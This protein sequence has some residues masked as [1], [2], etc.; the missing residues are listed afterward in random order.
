M[1]KLIVRMLR[2]LKNTSGQFISIVLILA[3]GSMLFAG[4]FGAQTAMTR[5]VDYYYDRQNLADVWLY[6]KG[7]SQD[8][9]DTLAL[10][11]KVHSAEGRYAYL[12]KLKM[13]TIDSELMIHSITTINSSLLS[14]GVLPTQTD[15]IMVDN[16]YARANKLKLKDKLPISTDSGI[17]TVTIT[18]F[19]YNPEAVV[20]QKDAS[21]SSVSHSEFG[22]AYATNN[23]L[24]GLNRTTTVYVN[25]LNEMDQKLDD[26]QHGLDDAAKQ[27]ADAQ[28]QYSQS[29]SNAQ[30]EL[31]RAQNQLN[32]AKK[33]LEDGRAT[34]D[35]QR[36]NAT[37]QFNK[38][39][40]QLD[41]ASVQLAQ[42]KQQAQIDLTNGQK[43][44]DETKKQMDNGQSEL[45]KQRQEAQAQFTKLQAPL[46]DAKLQLDQKEE[47]LNTSFSEYQAIRSQL[48]P[49]QQEAQDTD[50]TARNDLLAK[51]KEALAVQQ[52]QLK[53]KQEQVQ[54]QLTQKE[55]QL[56]RAK[57]NYENGL[58]EFS[59]RKVSMETQLSSAQAE[60]D[61]KQ[62]QLNEQWKKGQ[63]TLADK[64]AQLANAQK[65][66]DEGLQQYVAKKTDGGAQ[67]SK[68]E[69]E[70]SDKRLT[71]EEKRGDFVDEKADAQAQL[72]TAVKN[73]QE[74][75]VRTNN[76]AAIMKLVKANDSYVTAFERKDQISY[77]TV[78]QSLDPLRS[79]SLIFPL[80]F[81][82]V[83]AVIAFISI[84]KMVETQRTQ[85]AVMQAIGISRNKIRTSFLIY[86]FLAAVLG[87]I[88]FAL[89]GNLLIP[90]YL[91]QVFTTRL[92]MPDLVVSI[93]PIYI[94]LP[95][96]FAF[97]STGAAALLALQKTLREDPAHGMRP[98]PPKT[99]KETL[100]E[101]SSW[102]WNRLASS[103]RLVCRN[104]LRNKG[105][106][107]LSSVGVIASVTLLVTGFS[108]KNS[109]TDV[110]HSVV[111]GAGYDIAIN[112]NETVAD[113]TALSFPY[114]AS[115]VELTSVKKAVV[116]LGEGVTLKAQIV[117]SGSSLIHLVDP[118]GNTIPIS[119][120]SFIIPQ[121]IAQDYA[122]NV[123]DSMNVEINNT[124]YH[125]KITA[126]SEQ[127]LAK[128]L[129][130]SQDLA[131]NAGIEIDQKM[132]LVKL[133]NPDNT[134]HLA[135]QLKLDKTVSDVT[136]RQDLMDKSKD[137]TTMLNAII[138]VITLAAAMLAIT[139]I[140][141][142]TSVNI[143]ERTREYATLMALGHSKKQITRMMLTENTVLTMLGSIVGLPVGYLLFSYLTTIISR[144]DLTLTN[145]PSII[146]LLGAVGFSLLFVFLTNLLL[147][148]K[149][150][151]ISLVET[152][153]GVE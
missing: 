119:N 66:Y 6:F 84:S 117:E 31:N 67:L 133:Q 23:T 15:E 22:V 153:K 49:E 130:I 122:V 76:P 77:K 103:S 35:Q 13:N 68:A 146:A 63:A 17:H 3:I 121:N 50:F 101:R 96:V 144:G 85:I 147:S 10:N 24:I 115:T 93:Y 100:I 39:Q 42:K 114:T 70:I 136:T 88:G 73:Y 75:V 152:L 28:D 107:L 78:D 80:I 140:Y 11:G 37:D 25:Q 40:M 90:K 30:T 46:T 65:T 4:M 149:I 51:Q 34:L 111:D 145:N 126:I 135:E 127:Y 137:I 33:Q 128:S 72:D 116:A 92:D 32:V 21:S 12:A 108:L 5:S 91:I 36:K 150:N 16:K 106:M 53:D 19:F 38:S 29:K 27:I 26:A 102:V 58:K 8:E 112:Y 45:N 86:A 20:V 134:G 124:Q 74:V 62:Q 105:R 41:Q 95:L 89:I 43:K 1:N 118:Q 60:I 131:H 109:A 52:Q 110:V 129:Y 54:S 99:A 18:G 7:I 56:A 79:L 98:R 148:P 87:S 120:N 47:I 57:A 64:E 81:F 82:L 123:G 59:T 55:A 113:K 139:V 104:M 97:L 14:E 94:I 125:F 141:N 143:L 48:P 138:L 83:A 61:T 2:G 151:K 132:A 44:L 71:L 69:K 142:I 9:I